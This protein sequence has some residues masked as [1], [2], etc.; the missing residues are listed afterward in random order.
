[1]QSRIAL[2]EAG[3]ALRSRGMRRLYSGNR[4]REHAPNHAPRWGRGHRRSGE[5]GPYTGSDLRRFV[6]GATGLEPVT[7]SVSAKHREPLCYTP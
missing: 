5:V 3:G 7:S 1:M 4:V 6:V 2:H